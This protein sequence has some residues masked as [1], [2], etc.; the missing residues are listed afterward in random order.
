MQPLTVTAS[1]FEVKN[2]LEPDKLF[3]VSRFK[4]LI[5]RTRPHKHDNYYEIIVLFEGAG[6]HWLDAEPFQVAPPTAYVLKPGQLHCWQFTGVPKGF[7]VLFKEEWVHAI[8]DA[9]LFNLLKEL[10]QEISLSVGADVHLLLLEIEKEYLNPT[11]HSQ[12]VLQGLLQVLFA[13]LL[14]NRKAVA[15]VAAGSEQ[16]FRKFLSLLRKPGGPISQRVYEYACQLGVSPQNLNAI[17][18]RV[19]GKKAS[20]LIAEQ[21][22]LESKRYLLHTDHTI[23]EIAYQ[24]SFGDPSHFV[25][26]FKK[27]IGQ[28]PKQFKSANQL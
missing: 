15:T 14:Q 9:H 1:S 25:K 19:S 18:R 20:E 8:H 3:K 27:Y 10:E 4:E 24:L 28:T 5:K 26:Y 11:P 16:L 6:F 12:V 22:I 23:S 21:V 17:C 7:A 2:K 13:R